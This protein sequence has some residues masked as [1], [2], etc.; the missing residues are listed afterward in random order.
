M[1]PTPVR[2]G[3]GIFP[4]QAYNQ[5][6]QLVAQNPLAGEWVSYFAPHP[7]RSFTCN[8]NLNVQQELA[9]VATLTIAYVGSR[10][11]HL[12]YNTDDAN[13]VMP[14]LTPMGYV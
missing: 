10:G 4:A 2:S 8:W 6:V 7:P 14:T 9:Q 3:K 1:D 12:P 11:V 5:A 13:I